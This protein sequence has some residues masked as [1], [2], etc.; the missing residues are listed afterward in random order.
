MRNKSLT[1]KD[2]NIE[3]I[4]YLQSIKTEGLT[5]GG[6]FSKL[7]AEHRE[8]VNDRNLTKELLDQKGVELN[9]ALENIKGLTLQIEE[10]NSRPPQTVEVEKEKEVEKQLIGLQ[11]ICEPD[12]ATYDRMRVARSWIRKDEAFAFTNENYPE[13]LS[14]HA[15]N[16]FLNEEYS[17]LKK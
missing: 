14:I 17:H 2:A 8:A 3:D 12:Q 10:L 1:I 16:Y 11:F 15:I 13:K 5:N 7:V 9:E 4:E 6:A